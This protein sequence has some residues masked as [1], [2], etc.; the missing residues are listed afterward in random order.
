MNSALQSPSLCKAYEPYFRIGAALS[1]RLIADPELAEIVCRHFSSITADNQMKP[2]S[3]LNLE[4][5]L[6]QGDPCHA[7][8]DFT[9][10]DALLS[11]ARDH[12]IPVRYHTLA[13]HNQTPVWFFKEKWENDFSA[14]FASKEVMLAR[15]EN[16]ILDVMSHVNTCFPGVVYTWDV[17][18]EAIEPGQDGP[19]LYRTRSPWFMSTGQDFL[20]AAF[21]AARKGAAPGQTLCYNDY[22]AFDPIKRDAIIDMLKTLQAEGLVDTMGMQGHYVLQDLNVAACETAA[23]AYAALGLK[24][25]VTELDIHCNSDDAAHATA[26]TEAYRSWF[27]MMKQLKAEG[28][29]IE[30]VTFW[31]VTDAD[32]WLP[33]FRREPSFP[34][35]ISADRKAK[36]AFEAVLEAARS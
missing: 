5:T 26:L 28:I 1:S 6:A 32:S 10:V 27:T 4:N 25:Q 24:L 14:P 29:D 36:P 19:G 33:G 23:R 30:A 17:V 22:N 7:A 3:V 2:F 9:R 8:V 12:G 20:P 18:N 11:F 31:G 21:R 34:L 13:W 16:Y 15:L 35:L